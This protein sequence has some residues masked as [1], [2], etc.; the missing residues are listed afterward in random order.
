MVLVVKKSG[1]SQNTKKNMKVI[2]TQTIELRKKHKKL[3]LR[4]QFICM[5]SLVGVIIVFDYI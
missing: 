1:Y 4:G 3:I 5:I 2:P